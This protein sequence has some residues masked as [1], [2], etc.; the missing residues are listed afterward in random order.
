[1]PDGT[2]VYPNADGTYTIGGTDYA[3]SKVIPNINDL[4]KQLLDLQER[5]DELENELQFEKE[6]DNVTDV[7]EA[8]DDAVASYE[9]D[10][11]EFLL[12]SRITKVF[13]FCLPFDF[14][15]G[16]KLLSTSPVPP[17][18]DVNFDIP[19][20]G[21]YPGTH[22]VITLDLGL[23]SKYFTVVRWVTTILFI[24]SLCFLTYKLI[25]W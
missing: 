14:V 9:G 2:V 17:K 21:A 23:Y 24:L 6:K 16:M 8:V 3:P 13:P 5:I 7:S 19:S 1:M 10:L 15:R 12:N 22:N 25:K 4:L 20:F 18:F 11:S